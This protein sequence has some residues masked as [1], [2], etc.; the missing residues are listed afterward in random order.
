MN[1]DL[2]YP[3]TFGSAER[4]AFDQDGHFIFPGLLTAMA[5]E[6]LTAALARVQELVPTAVEG[7]EPTR[8]A[9]EFDSYLE[10]LISHP[11]LLLLVR[12][13]LGID[14]RYDHCVALNR[15][16]GNNGSA[17]H[18]HEY[19]EDNPGLGFV[20]I[21]FYVN[22]FNAD[23]GGLKVVPGSHLFRDAQINAATDDDLRHNW[24]AGKL[25]PD[26]GQALQIQGL[27]APAGSV[28]LMW[29]HAAHGVTP[30]QPNSSTRWCVVYAY[31]N[32]GRPSGARWISAAFEK[33]DHA[34]AAGLMSLY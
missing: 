25:H 29:T 16:G 19:A 14:I 8:F 34:E 27:D 4:A 26:T 13:V 11:Q 1:K 3:Y 15:P 24:M 6:R 22:G 10:R 23:D 17:W 30:R 33:K 32:P 2:F 12:Q 5:Q 18:S 20:R 9:A 7:Y 21:F 31:R 28:V